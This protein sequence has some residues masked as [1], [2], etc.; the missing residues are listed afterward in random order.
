MFFTSAPSQTTRGHLFKLNVRR[1][2][3][4]VRQNIF[5]ARVVNYWNSYPAEIV[6]APMIDNF[7]TKKVG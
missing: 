1:S 3:L 4:N 7:K 2:R 6:A 5:S